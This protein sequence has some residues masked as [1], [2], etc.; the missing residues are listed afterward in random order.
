LLIRKYVILLFFG[1]VFEDRILE[2]MVAIKLAIEPYQRKKAKERMLAGKPSD[3]I[4]IN[5]RC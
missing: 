3:N 5:E 2:E 4:L 1:I